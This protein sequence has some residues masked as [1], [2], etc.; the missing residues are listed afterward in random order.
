MSAP[1]LF[2]KQNVA[3]EPLYNRWYAWCYLVSP[4]TA[5]LV[6]ANLHVKIMQSFVANPAIHVAALKNPELMGGPYLNYGVE[7][8]PEIKELLEWTLKEQAR[9]IQFAQAVAE[10]DKL[11]A[12]SNGF[13][14]EEQY[15]KVPDILRGYVELTYDLNNRASPRFIEAL[16]YR[17]PFFRESSQS[18]SLRLLEGD[19][20]PYIYSTPRL[21]SLKDTVH[22]HVPFRAEAIDALFAMRRTPGPVEP[23]R[24]A[25]GIGAEK[26]EMFSTLFTDKPPRPAPRY[27][28]KGVRVRYF[29][30]ACV[31]IETREVSILTD[32]VVSYD[33]PTDLPR[34]THADLP[35]RIDYVV[36]THA[37]ADHLMFETL[38][39]L[40]DRIGTVIVP[41]NG[42]GSLA[43]P[44]IKL[45]LR[46]TG[47]RNVV[48]LGDM[49][50]LDVP[51]G[52]ITG[53]PFIGEHADL[54]IQSKI[55]HLVQLEGKSLL[56][57]A[58][59]NALEPR[60]Y[61]HVHG[62]VGNI[63]VLFL[64]MESEG[65]PLS[66][67]YGPLLTTPLPRKMDQSRRLNGSNSERAIEIVR[68]LHPSQVI[69]YAMGREPWLGHIMA[70][71]YS[72]NSPQL[73][74]ARKLLAHC[75]EHGIASAFP[76]G[77]AEM[78][79]G[80]D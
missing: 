20:R 39:Q 36:I 65:G 67:M 17:S 45:M 78:F 74:E 13:S 56:M 5:P 57:A 34:Y 8:V 64:G 35:E 3:L 4:A 62:I 59:S 43:D 40:R 16:L 58:D 44:S 31:L 69:I 10:L 30:H 29:G 66:W 80:R 26:A 48:A 15:K 25:L 24:E 53:L 52:S 7:R 28:G 33:F 21:D 11:L 14:L 72:E 1:S 49:E 23:I 37:H 22:A 12:T 42:G 70:M 76:F 19:A 9:S 38:V 61:D 32:P 47:F 71:G 18:V 60:L 79:L 73:I 51:G 77:Q 6:V 2:L 63:D 55:A 68:R 50:S 27:D 75:A 46:N 54:N 41:A